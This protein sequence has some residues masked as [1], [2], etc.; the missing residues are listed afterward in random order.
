LSSWTLSGIIESVVF[1]K[2]TSNPWIV[3]SLLQSV[4][5][6]VLFVILSGSSSELRLVVFSEGFLDTRILRHVI[7]A[8]V[9][10]QISFLVPSHNPLSSVRLPSSSTLHPP[11]SI[12]VCELLPPPI[13][14]PLSSI[15]HPTSPTKPVSLRPLSSI[16]INSLPPATLFPFSPPRPPFAY[17]YHLP[18]RPS[19]PER[20]GAC[21]T[22]NDF[23]SSTGT[24]KKHTG[25]WKMSLTRCNLRAGVRE[26]KGE[27]REEGGGGGGG[28]GRRREEGG[29]R[30][31]RLLGGLFF[32]RVLMQQKNTQV[33][34]RSHRKLEARPCW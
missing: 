23:C 20:E 18:W 1:I 12:L 4:T 3:G 16:L 17:Q 30:K 26:W 21:S 11:A 6:V 28:G 15:L 25:Y 34:G 33:A 14:C 22:K 7:S 31:G 5:I 32:V 2:T 13:L 29:R 24:T 27:R 9:I 10:P 8:F 19:L